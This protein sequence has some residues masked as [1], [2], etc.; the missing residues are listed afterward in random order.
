MGPLHVVLMD[1]KETEPVKKYGKYG[2]VWKKQH[3]IDPERKRHS[4]QLYAI[5]DTKPWFLNRVAVENPFD[6]SGGYWVLS[7]EGPLLSKM[8]KCHQS[9]RIELN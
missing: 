4:S 8:A 9:Y 7:R 1:L 2:K 6:S 3:S 5:W